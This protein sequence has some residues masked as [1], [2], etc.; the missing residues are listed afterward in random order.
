M[1]TD[2]L[3]VL[4]LYVL[5]LNTFCLLSVGKLRCSRWPPH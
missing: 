5:R 1:T 4:P 3:L 2:H